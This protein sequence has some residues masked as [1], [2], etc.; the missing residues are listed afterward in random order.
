MKLLFP[1]V[2]AGL[3]PFAAAAQDSASPPESMLIQPAAEVDLDA[4]LWIKR[5]VVVFADSSAD[6]RYA[7]QIDELQADPQRLLDRDVVV[8]T[9]TD[10]SAQSPLR[11]RLRPRGFMLV[12]VGKDGQV[13]LRKPYPWTVRELSRSI[14]KSTERKREVEERRNG[15]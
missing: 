3:I 12:L 6:P 7:Q 4:F 5:P 14:D 10:P 11:T 1:I 8:L 15:S 2:F 13:K 9:D